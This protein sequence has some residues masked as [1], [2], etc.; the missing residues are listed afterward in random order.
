MEGVLAGFRQLHGYRLV[1][2]KPEDFWDLGFSYAD[3][4]PTR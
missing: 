3:L 1:R 4:A 2:F